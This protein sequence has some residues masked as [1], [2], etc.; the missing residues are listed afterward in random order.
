MH[1]H[2]ACLTQKVLAKIY[3]WGTHKVYTHEDIIYESKIFRFTVLNYVYTYMRM[4]YK[5]HR[6]EAYQ[7]CTINEQDLRYYGLLKPKKFNC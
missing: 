5:N 4:L 3:S 6:Y 7:S 1:L 2:I